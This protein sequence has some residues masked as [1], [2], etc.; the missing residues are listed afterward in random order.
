MAQLDAYTG[1]RGCLTR[2]RRASAPPDSSTVLSVGIL[3]LNPPKDTPSKDESGS[4]THG[5]GFG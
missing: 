1:L 4:D 2:F 3:L 5:I